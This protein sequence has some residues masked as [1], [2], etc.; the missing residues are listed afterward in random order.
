MII[1]ILYG[2]KISINN[3]RLVILDNITSD[4]ELLENEEKNSIPLKDIRAII[5]ENPYSSISVSSL[6]EL[7]RN[8]INLIICNEKF[9]PELQ[10]L[11]LFSNYKITERVTEQINWQDERKKEAFRE[12]II[13]KVLHQSDLLAFIG[14]IREKD[15][16][17]ILM[18]SLKNKENMTPQEIVSVEG[19]AARIYFQKLF[20]REF[21][22]FQNDLTNS[23]LNYGYTILRTL[24]SKVVVGKGLHPTLGIQHNSIFNNYNLV[25]DL[26]EIFRPMVDYLVY[27]NLKKDDNE[28]LTKEHRNDLLKIYFQRIE[29][30]GNLFNIDYVVEKYIDNFVGFMNNTK[31]H[32]ELPK[33]VISEY[34]Y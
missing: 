20:L 16:L 11:D 29:L 6:L 25:D 3:N 32:F 30:E 9:Q 28:T 26:M 10:V 31:D 14:A 21:K 34:E 1:R 5:L 17:L 33:L 18:E 27:F 23:A 7:S 19:V 12:I 2:D 8:K 15:E 22:R 4:G 13:R 24:V